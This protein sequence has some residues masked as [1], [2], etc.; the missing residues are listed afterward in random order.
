MKRILCLAALLAAFALPARA[1]RTG[2]LGVGLQAGSPMGVTAKWWYNDAFAVDGGIGYGNAGV[3]YTDLSFNFWNLGKLPWN[4]KTN[5]YVAAGPRIATDD[6]GQFAIRSLA[7]VGFWPAGSPVEWFAEIGPTFKV[8]PDHETGI[9][10]AVG[11][12]YYFRVTVA[13]LPR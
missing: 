13:K 6:G 1:E 8:T 9:D 3:F 11:F 4:G 10:G 7:G 5:L 12:R 2:D